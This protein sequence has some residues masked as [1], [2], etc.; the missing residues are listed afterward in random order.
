MLLRYFYD[1]KL[2]QASYFVGCQ[3][4][5]EAIVI[6][7][8]RD[9]EPYLQAA[10]AEG[11]RII[12][13]AETHIHADF[14]SGARELA[15]RCGA[16]LF[17]SD[18]G[19]E[20]WKYQY[21]DAYDH[22]LLKDGD[23]FKIGNIRFET[24][25][26]PGHT[27]EH[28]SLLLT[29]TAGA[30]QPMGIFSGDF[31]FVGDVGRP[32]LL[33]KAASMAGTAE[34]GARQMFHSLQRFKQLP[35]YLQLWPG[36]GSGSACGK[37]LGAVPSSTIGYEKM[38]NWALSHDDE[39]SF[40]AELLAGQPEPP[41]Y[42]AMMKHL[43]KVG[44]P[45]L[46]RLALPPHLPFH[47]LEAALSEPSSTVVDTRTSAAFAASHIPGTIN[48]PYDYS[49]A[50]WA[51]WLLDY[52][53]PFYL[54]A[55]QHALQEVA[56]QLASIGL[57]NSAGYFE[58]AAIEAWAEA[59]HE[60]QCYENVP[61]SRIAEQVRA[62]QALILDVRNR[63]EWDEGHIPGA[64]HLMLGYLAEG[65]ENL[66]TNGKQLVVQCQTGARS[67]IG[68]SILQAHGITNVAN[69]M[70]GFRDWQL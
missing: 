69:M 7:P 40:V 36:H 21:V 13:A 4:T 56:R 43:N 23:E 64:Q 45:I 53:R 50:N 2:A 35:D 51:G 18:N 41:R 24:F 44:P 12:A 65:S 30:D 29:D 61:P 54:I 39:Q 63:S 5:N 37:A 58:T 9:V 57:D 26:S 10:E 68:A 8:A 66:S 49:F 3:Q 70:G 52:E 59:G 34:V 33:E 6:D 38:F 1:E 17:L 15:E 67:A 42:F 60:L 31:V 48:I 11:M 28:I 16:T 25:H 32:D 22:V 62:G 55:D 20:N 14:I 47:R 46:G 19:D 27:P